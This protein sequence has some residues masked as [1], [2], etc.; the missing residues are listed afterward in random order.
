MRRRPEVSSVVI[1]NGTKSIGIEV[2]RQFLKRYNIQYD[3]LGRVR[4]IRPVNRVV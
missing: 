1:R 4:F 2:A 3:A